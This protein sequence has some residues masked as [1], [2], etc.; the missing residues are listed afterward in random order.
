LEV[1]CPSDEADYQTI[2]AAQPGSVAAPTAG[3]HFTQELLQ[4]V[5]HAFLTLH[6][7][8]GTFRPIRS[9]NILEHKMEAEP[10]EISR[11]LSQLAKQSQRIVAVGTTVTRAIESRPGL[12]PGPGCTDLFIYPPYRFQRVGALLTNFHLPRSTPLLLVSAFAGWDLIRRAYEEAMSK[13]YFFYSFG[14]AMLIL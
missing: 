12:E 13:G 10:Y 2:Y 8:P 5:P 11:E 1:E 9:E 7:G 14:D 3:L 4:Q 6:V